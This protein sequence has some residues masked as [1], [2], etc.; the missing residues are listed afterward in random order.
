MTRNYKQ[1][2]A[3]CNVQGLDKEEVVNEIS[4][5]RTTSLKELTD[6]EWFALICW[7]TPLS[8]AHW[9]PK[10]GDRQRKKMISIARQMNWHMERGVDVGVSYIVN[11]IDR[12]A[13][14]QKYKKPLMEHTEA[15]LNVLLTI[16]EQKVFADYLRDLNK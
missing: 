4:K 13:R 1:F 2:Y 10:P 9:Q 8:K 3:L 12:W 7:L 6:P 11:R 16:F 5:G 14:A 15:E